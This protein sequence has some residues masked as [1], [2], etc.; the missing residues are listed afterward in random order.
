MNLTNSMKYAPA[1]FILFF[2]SIFSTFAST[3]VGVVTD[4]ST[5]KPL[6]YASVFIA[7]T[8]FGTNTMSDGSFNLNFTPGGASQ[9]VVAHLGYQTFSIA[10][11]DVPPGKPLPVSLK[12]KSQLLSTVSVVG[13]DPNRKMNM[14]EFLFGFLGESEFGKKC[15]ILNPDVLHLERRWIK[16]KF[17]EYE[18]IAFADS[19]LIIENKAL[20]YT[21]RYTME[22][23]HMT[24]YSVTFKGYPLFLDNL[25]RSKN[26]DKTLANRERAYQG[27]QMHF[28]RSL[29]SKNLQEEGFKIY[30]VEK[31]PRTSFNNYSTY[32]LMIDTIFVPESDHYMVQTEKQLNLYN[33]LFK[34][35]NASA[36]VYEGP[37]E[38]RYSLNGE[39]RA[40]GAFIDYYRGMTRT[41]GQQSSLVLLQ[42]NSVVFY[43]NGACQNAGTLVTIGYWSFKKV[44][45]IMPWDYQPPKT[46]KH[47]VTLH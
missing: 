35:E 23:F 39:D 25:A 24:R 45:E 18:L 4:A 32:G 14:S 8:T 12:I 46:A 5:G 11:N 17:A 43:P 21:I 40:Y 27:S 2:T 1:L 34:M 31:Q 41:L 38:V 16:G 44:G 36:L 33:H 29:Y 42:G 10:V 19:A 3:I 47:V 28:F 7:G 15:T 20:G 37:F 22:N 13:V 9:L 30:Q 6:E 26:Q